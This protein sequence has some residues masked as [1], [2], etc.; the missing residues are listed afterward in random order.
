[1]KY[2]FATGTRHSGFSSVS[3]MNLSPFTKDFRGPERNNESLTTFSSPCVST[4]RKALYITII[5]SEVVNYSRCC[6]A[7]MCDDGCQRCSFISPRRCATSVTIGTDKEQGQALCL[8]VCLFVKNRS[9]LLGVDTYLIQIEYW[10]VSRLALSIVER[11]L[12]PAAAVCE[13]GH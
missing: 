7:C 2:N 4:I 8:F 11:L 10:L 6:C 13:F 5:K 1:M 3:R 12:P 9:V